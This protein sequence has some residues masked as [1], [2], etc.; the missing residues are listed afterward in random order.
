MPGGVLG[1]VAG[2]C[3]AK[4]AF[5]RRYPTEVL[6]RTKASVVDEPERKLTLARSLLLSG[7]R[8]FRLLETHYEHVKGIW[9]DRFEKIY[10]RWR[11]FVD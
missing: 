1:I 9:D 2:W 3:P 5:G 10:G 7:R 4:V 11:G 8:A 6:M